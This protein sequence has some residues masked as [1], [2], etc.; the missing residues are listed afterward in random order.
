M[1]AW[2]LSNNYDYICIHSVKNK[3]K[4]LSY[5]SGTDFD[6]PMCTQEWWLSYITLIMKKSSNC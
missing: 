6:P 1:H 3:L 5:Q 4:S 2:F